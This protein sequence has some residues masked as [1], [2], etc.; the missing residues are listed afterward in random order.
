MQ[1]LFA[2]LLLAALGL[3]VVFGSSGYAVEIGQPG[4]AWKNLPGTDGKDHSLSDLKK[5][6]VVV[7]CFTCNHC[8][9]A[10]AYEQPPLPGHGGPD[11]HGHQFF[12][13]DPRKGRGLYLSGH[14]QPVGPHQ[15]YETIPL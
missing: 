2:L 13:V 10:V 7:V 5:A 1:R 14:L 9:V 15:P 12:P 11:R 3:L 4:Y 8:P 6:D